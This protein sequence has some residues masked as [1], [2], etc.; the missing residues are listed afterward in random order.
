MMYKG[1]L[2]LKLSMLVCW[3]IIDDSFSLSLHKGI[4]VLIEQLQRYAPWPEQTL[5]K[6]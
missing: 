5:E 2:W 3:I 6:S 4:M 1:L